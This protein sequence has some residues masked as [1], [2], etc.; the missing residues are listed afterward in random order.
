MNSITLLDEHTANR[1]AA[2]EVIERP[3]SVVKELVENSLDAGAS[4]I[5]IDLEEGGKELIR[6]TDNGA[7]MTKEDAVLS[8]QRHATSK[9]STAED[10]FEIQTLGFRGEALPSIASVSHLELATKNASE[11]AGTRL[12]VEAG[13]IVDLEEVG[14]PEGTMIAVRQ[15]FF[16]TPARH[17]FLKSNQTELGYIIEMVGRLAV[18]YHTVSFRLTHNGQEL[19]STSSSPDLLNAIV[20]VYGRDVARDVVAIEH[21]APGIKVTGYVS[22]PSLTR[23]NRSQQVFFVNNRL[24]RHKILTHALD[25]SF[26]GLLPHGRYVI[27]IIMIE[28]PPDLVDVNVHPAKAEVRFSRD[29]E[30]HSAVFKAIRGTLM[31]GGAAPE[32]TE[33]VTAGPS[34]AQGGNFQIQQRKEPLLPHENVDI[35]AF[36]SAL[37]QRTTTTEHA[38][39]PFDWTN[40]SPVSNPIASTAIPTVDL[41]PM[42]TPIGPISLSSV[43]VVGQ[44]RNMYIV[45]QCDDGIVIIDQHVAHERVIFD[46]LKATAEAKESHVQYLMIPFTLHLSRRESMI[47]QEKLDE[48]KSIG[49]E[50]EPFGGDSFV[51]RGVPA[52]IAQKDY[53]QSLRDIVDELVEV[54]VAR[55]LLP[56]QEQILIT[57]ACKMA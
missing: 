11:P 31:V 54:S 19:I 34:P 44:A 57:A 8:L 13:T 5:I 17:K 52:N 42:E 16:N 14:M 51:V 22:R 15:L 32:I 1:I 30:I 18:S 26:R 38:D 21:T 6:V 3:A 12:R 56:K 9:I 35:S 4:R 24:V 7:G 41:P 40:K 23:A 46:R 53:S 49:F 55:H 39:D 37:A 20:S 48:L 28:I 27:A 45:A 43:Q 25:E 36:R 2:G 29:G 50:L 10:L 33:T 47:V